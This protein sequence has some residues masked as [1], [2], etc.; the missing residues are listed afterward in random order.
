MNFWQQLALF[1]SVLGLWSAVLVA[2]LKWMLDKSDRHV[3]ERLDLL[4]A[5]MTGFRSE[6]H[7]MEIELER[8]KRE[9][10]ERFVPRDEWLQHGIALE[11]KLDR[12]GRKI[13]AAFR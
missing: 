9:A 4:V 10:S 3:S 7:K 5:Q 12:L 6:V 8:Y 11:G 1:C 2:T 13:D